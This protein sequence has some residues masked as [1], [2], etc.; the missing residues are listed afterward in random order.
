MN[1]SNLGDIYFII[2]SRPGWLADC[3][4]AGY[5]DEELDHMEKLD[6]ELGGYQPEEEADKW[7]KEV[8]KSVGPDVYF[9]EEEDNMIDLNKKIFGL[10][11]RM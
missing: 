11:D 9:L 3:K 2:R 10:Y 8:I 4:E 7:A 5:S 6:D 1:P